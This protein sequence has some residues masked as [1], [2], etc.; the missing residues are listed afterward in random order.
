ML[1]TRESYYAA[2]SER[3]GHD[4][5]KK[6]SEACIGIAGL[7]GL[8][9]NAALQLARSGVGRLV[10]TDF[11]SVDLAN[12]HRQCYPLESVGKAKTDALEKEIMRVN[13]WCVVEKHNIRI[14]P[15]NISVFDHCTIIIEAFDKAEEKIML[16]ENLRDK[17]LIMG[18]GMA[19]TGPADDIVTKRV[20]KNLIVCGDGTSDV[21]KDGSFLSSRV[22]VCAAKQANAAL[23]IILGL[24]S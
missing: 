19:G 20:G 5:S 3:L 17:M 14:T 13:P 16:A 18:N 10:I 11:D 22:A 15:E 12:V 6:L 21:D 4:T 24:E 23:R 7:G 1:I 9:S 8:G 2:L